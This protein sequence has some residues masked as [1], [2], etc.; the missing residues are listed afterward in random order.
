MREENILALD[1]DS[2][3]HQR[4]GYTAAPRAILFANDTKKFGCVSLGVLKQWR[5]A[6]VVFPRETEG[7]TLSSALCEPG[8]VRVVPN[9]SRDAVINGVNVRIIEIQ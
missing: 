1:I 3:I 9:E 4:I 6:Y 7:S 8:G 5:I 2:S